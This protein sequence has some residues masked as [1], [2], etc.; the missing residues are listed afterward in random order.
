MSISAHAPIVLIRT[1]RNTRISEESA[2]VPGQVK[3][4]E[5]ALADLEGETDESSRY[6]PRRMAYSATAHLAGYG[7]NFGLCCYDDATSVA[8]RAK[9]FP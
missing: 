2:R 3:S 8:H 7:P 9:P 5:M 1:W 6:I 4:R